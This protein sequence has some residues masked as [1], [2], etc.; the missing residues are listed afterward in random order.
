[1]MCPREGA[2]LRGSPDP[3][4]G[5][6]LPLPARTFLLG[7]LGPRPQAVV[8]GLCGAVGVMQPLVPPVP[9][10][11][12]VSPPAHPGAGIHLG[13]VWSM[14]ELSQVQVMRNNDQEVTEQVVFTH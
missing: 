12:V 11:F 4:R 10:V 5:R 6:V 9:G 13:P 7:V 2:V 14:A 8:L 1:M 3:S